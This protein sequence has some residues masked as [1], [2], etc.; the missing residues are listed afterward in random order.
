M[1]S[2]YTLSLSTMAPIESELLE[3]LESLDKGHHRSGEMRRLI[4]YG[5]VTLISNKS[6]QEATFDSLDENSK[7]VLMEIINQKESPIK[8]RDY[9]EYELN[10][11]LKKL[12]KEN[13]ELKKINLINK[14]IE[15]RE[16]TEN[17][18]LVDN[19]DKVDELAKYKKKKDSELHNNI[20][21]ENNIDKKENLLPS[22]EKEKKDSIDLSNEA[23]LYFQDP[24]MSTS[25]VFHLNLDEDIKDPLSL[26]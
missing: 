14:E 16:L 1:R 3:Y 9:E 10:S 26:F 6:K 2:K 12:K 19:N 24:E 21:K 5:F 15:E 18:S 20:N 25:D 13:E 22:N 23:P 11:A 17:I 7:K 8:K 4:L